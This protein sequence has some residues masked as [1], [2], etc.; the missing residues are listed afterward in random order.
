MQLAAV[1][2]HLLHC[3]EE[4][5]IG[6]EAAVLDRG[7]DACE[8]LQHPL[9]RADIQV[10]HLRVAHLPLWQ[11][12]RWP[13]GRDL[14]MRPLALD[15]VQMRLRGQRDGVGVAPWVDA[16]AVHDDEDQWARHSRHGNKLSFALGCPRHRRAGRRMHRPP[17]PRCGAHAA[18]SAA[19]VVYHGAPPQTARR[20]A[21]SPDGRGPGHLEGWNGPCAII[22]RV[23]RS[24]RAPPRGRPTASRWRVWRRG[25]MGARG[26]RG[27]RSVSNAVSNARIVRPGAAATDSGQ[28]FVR[29]VV[30]TVLLTLLIFFA[31]HFSVQPF[32][33]DGPS[34]QPGLHTGEY[35][36]VNL[37]TYDFTAPQRGDVIVFHPPDSPDTPYV[38]RIV[39]IPGDT[40]SIT[41]DA[42]SVNGVKLNEPYI[43]ALAPGQSENPSV[44]LHIKLDKDQY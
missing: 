16:E 1:A 36:V 4:R 2:L 18:Q 29:E 43:S 9:A 8:L 39:A 6:E 20:A 44:I 38:K 30:E 11:A 21:H 23:H 27:G 14:G 28:K 10:P 33:V 31:V 19:L 41:R 3:F 26:H 40:V 37:L 22:R 15:A 32:R 7:G 24:A 13:G 42:I 12:Y 25:C 35:V 17:A 34:M 5:R